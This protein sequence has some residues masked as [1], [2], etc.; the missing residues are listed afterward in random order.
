[1]LLEEPSAIAKVG[2]LD[3]TARAK[4]PPCRRAELEERRQK[5]KKS[6]A[7]VSAKKKELREHECGI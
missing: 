2:D 5:K 4:G 6:A 7:L 1:L 3:R